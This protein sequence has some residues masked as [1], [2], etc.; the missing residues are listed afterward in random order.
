MGQEHGQD[1]L[2]PICPPSVVSAATRPT[3]P[4]L[5]PRAPSD[6]GPNSFVRPTPNVLPL[7]Y[8]EHAAIHSRPLV[9]SWTSQD[10]RSSSTQSL[11]PRDSPSDA[12][13]G[14]LLLI[15]VHGF[16]GNETSFQ[17]F[18]AHVHN[19]VT[20]S[21]KGSHVVHTKIYPRYKT[22]KKI[23]EGVRRF[24]CREK[25]VVDLF[26]LGPHE[27]PDTDVILLGHSLGGILCAEVALLAPYTGGGSELLRHRILG[28]INFDTP[29]L[30]MH[31]GV[32]A[33]GLGSLFRPA[34]DSRRA[35]SPRDQTASRNFRPG[36]ADNWAESDV[37][38]MGFGPT[39]STSATSLPKESSS[40]DLAVAYPSS[41]NTPI[42]DPSYNPPFPNDVRLAQ[43]TG[44]SNTWH[45]VNKHSSDLVKATKSY[46]SSHLEFGGCLADCNGLKTRYNRIRELEEG[47]EGVRVRFVNYYTAS[48]GR[49]KKDKELRG[50]AWGRFS[51]EEVPIAKEI[52]EPGLNGAKSGSPPARPSVFIEDSDGLTEAVANAFTDKGKHSDTVS[53]WV[54]DRDSQAYGSRN[55]E[56]V[57]PASL[58]EDETQISTT[59][60]LLHPGTCSTNPISPSVSPLPSETRSM[61]SLPRPDPIPLS[62]QIAPMPKGLD[63]LA[64]AYR[65]REMR[66]SLEKEHDR[67]MN[68]SGKAN[69]ISDNAIKDRHKDLPKKEENSAKE[70]AKELRRE[71]KARRKEE[72]K[73]TKRMK[74]LRKNSGKKVPPRTTS[75]DGG[76]ELR[77]KTSNT[78]ESD[79]REE[80]GKPPRPPR[81]KKFCLLPN[82]VNG[83]LDPC[84][85]RVYMPGVDEVSAHCGLFFMDGE[86]YEW[87]VRDVSERIV[88][89]TRQGSNMR[90]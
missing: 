6:V 59:T 85:V 42:N 61:A 89:W 68:V 45:F 14:T 77:P 21:L 84:W 79:I 13:Q 38:S 31:P 69:K 83:V 41:S 28:T 35:R 56:Y 65:D 8:T 22:R 11:Q 63:P 50:Q 43:R 54:G 10:P 32:I 25:K 88:H 7:P 4:P 53:G 39:A 72:D 2:K 17:S 52:L 82:R 58:S 73:E 27:S 15:Y 37:S 40:T 76:A 55:M 16:M 44:W 48:T 34:P 70:Q 64:P 67:Q 90:R 18:P 71:D 9:A 3:P 49:P 47:R 24:N 46:V 51:G 75:T 66:T 60:P 57:R 62:A 74:K 12:K 36:T 1:H 29:F 78:D 87:F 33:S 26:R 80:L 81:D 19:A 5:P 20:E 86:R 23:E 30:G